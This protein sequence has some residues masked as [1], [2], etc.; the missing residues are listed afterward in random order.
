[1]EGKIDGV[2]VCN[3]PEPVG[4]LRDDRTCQNVGV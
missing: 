3:H 4:P 2:T 1:M